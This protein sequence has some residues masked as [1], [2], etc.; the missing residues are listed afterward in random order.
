MLRGE[1][2]DDGGGG[3]DEFGDGVV[4][5]VGDPDVGAVVSNCV[6]ANEPVN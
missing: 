5:V 6:R 2:G 1:R 3:A 4:A